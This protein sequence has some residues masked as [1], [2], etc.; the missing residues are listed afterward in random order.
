MAIFAA[1]FISHHICDSDLEIRTCELSALFITLLFQFAPGFDLSFGI[2]MLYQWLSAM[3]NNAT[4]VF[5]H[6][7]LID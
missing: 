4:L 2:S 1:R 6:V 3:Q 5:S 7:M